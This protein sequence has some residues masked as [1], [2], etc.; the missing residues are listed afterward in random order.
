[1]VDYQMEAQFIIAAAGAGDLDFQ[2]KPMAGN[3]MGA[4]VHRL[5]QVPSN[6]VR[7]YIEKVASQLYNRDRPYQFCG[8]SFGAL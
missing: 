2:R 3:V 8:G 1:M 4:I 7:G 5:L 6:A